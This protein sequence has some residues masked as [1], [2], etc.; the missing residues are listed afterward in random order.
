MTK[1]EL[2]SKLMKRKR[3]CS[4]E[5]CGRKHASFGFCYLHYSRQRDGI[6]LDAP[7]REKGPD[8]QGSL[9]RG[10][11]V[12][13]ID[14]VRHLEHRLV[15]EQHIGRTLLRHENVHHKNG[16]R[17]D[18]RLEN[19]ELWNRQ[20]PIGQRA[21]DLIVWAKE[22]LGLYEPSALADHSVPR[23]AT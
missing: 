9:K 18:N 13:M 7:L 4:I 20:Q 23:T 21:S 11:R 12:L 3:L 10:Y 6:P 22:I 15:M 14:G 2:T 8:G 1:N 5:S 19:L 17:A 16:D